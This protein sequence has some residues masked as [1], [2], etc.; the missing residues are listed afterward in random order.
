LRGCHLIFQR[1]ALLLQSFGLLALFRD[2]KFFLVSC[3]TRALNLQTVGIQA[4]FRTR[5]VRLHLAERVP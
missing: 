4:L 2:Q 5:Q 1:L 3:R